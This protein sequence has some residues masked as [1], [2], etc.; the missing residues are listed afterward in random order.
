MGGDKDNQESD[1][2]NLP[3]TKSSQNS[4]G[5][6]QVRILTRQESIDYDKRM[7]LSG[8]SLVVSSRLRGSV[9]REKAKPV[10]NNDL[11][12]QDD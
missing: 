8:D 1:E 3:P 7:G 9:N 4:S 10:E 6:P 2:G 12:Q 5:R 11:S